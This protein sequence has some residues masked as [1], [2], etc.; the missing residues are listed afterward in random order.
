[1]LLQR[2]ITDFGADVPFHKVPAK[3]SEHYG[4]TVP[5]SSSRAITEK[6]A[7]EI[8]AGQELDTNI[9]DRQGV[10]VLI[11]EVDGC[12]IP[13]VKVAKQG[14]GDEKVDLRSTR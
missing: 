10:D 4:I 5:I 6:H 9:P 1:M 13:I 7:E 2:A 14:M 12:L 3:L 8:S 11:E